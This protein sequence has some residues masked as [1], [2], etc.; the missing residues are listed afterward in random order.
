[1][2]LRFLV[3]LVGDLHQPLH[4]GHEDDRGGN[5]IKVR[6]FGEDSNLHRVWDS[7]L[8]QQRDLDYLELTTEYQERFEA[9]SPAERRIILEP[10]PSSWLAE[11][12]DLRTSAYDLSGESNNL[13]ETYV[14]DNLPLIEEQLLR[15]GIR[16]AL[17]L[18]RI[19]ADSDFPT[20]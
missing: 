9:L 18:N 2:A 15:G 11:A 14:E 20:P 7:Q 17:L 4:A 13:G 16:L 3:H 6:W 5:D 10:R 8:L 19:F 1:M 12:I